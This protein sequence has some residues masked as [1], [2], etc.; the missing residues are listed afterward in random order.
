V[1]TVSTYLYLQNAFVSFMQ[2]ANIPLFFAHFFAELMGFCDKSSPK[3]IAQK[4]PKTVEFL[5]KK[6]DAPGP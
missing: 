6:K 5:N 4:P 2:C 1:S 3:I